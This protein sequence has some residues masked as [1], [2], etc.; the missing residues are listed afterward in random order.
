MKDIFFSTALYYS[1][2]LLVLDVCVILLKF[3]IV[4][5][6]TNMYPGVYPRE[7]VLISKAFWWVKGG[8]EG[9][10]YSSEGPVRKEFVKTIS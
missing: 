6:F 3:K 9:V 4:H 7:V 10:A 8:G 1:H 2:F 5:T